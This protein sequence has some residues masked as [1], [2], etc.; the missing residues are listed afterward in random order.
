MSS[1]DFNGLMN[2]L[3]DGI[4]EVINSSEEQTYPKERKHT[5]VALLSIINRNDKQQKVQIIIEYKD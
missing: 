1:R 3:K 2:T 5:R 4:Q